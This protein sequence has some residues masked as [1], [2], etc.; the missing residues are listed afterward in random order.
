MRKDRPAQLIITPL[1]KTE[2][3]ALM[4]SGLTLYKFIVQSRLLNEVRVQRP[5]TDFPHVRYI[6]I[7]LLES[8]I[9]KVQLSD[10]TAATDLWKVL[11]F[12]RLRT[13]TLPSCFTTL[14][15]QLPELSGG[16]LRDTVFFKDMPKEYKYTFF[17]LEDF[18]QHTMVF[19]RHLLEF[20]DFCTM[21][22]P[23]SQTESS[24]PR[25][26][27]LHKDKDNSYIKIVHSMVPNRFLEW[28][29]N[30]TNYED[31]LAC[32]TIKQWVTLM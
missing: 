7:N 14:S 29:T 30:M 28:L 8:L 22:L 31:I 20:H 5:D 17:T 32:K 21:L 19:F 25:I 10:V 1:S 24:D 6:D 27:P 16:T 9:A 12:T 4:L 26:P 13:R 2:E 3:S 11:E 15:R 23:E 18:I